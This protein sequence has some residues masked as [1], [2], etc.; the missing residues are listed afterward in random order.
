MSSE[1]T[2]CKKVSSRVNSICVFY[3]TLCNVSIAEVCVCDATLIN[4]F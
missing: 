2:D 3:S 1:A 4:L